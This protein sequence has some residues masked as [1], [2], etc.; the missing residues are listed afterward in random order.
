MT[1]ETQKS[2]SLKSAFG[3]LGNTLAGSYNV[4][5]GCVIDGPTGQTMM[6]VGTLNVAAT[7]A[8]IAWD[9]HMK[10]ERNQMMAQ[11]AVQNA[12]RLGQ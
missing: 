2:Q 1:Q 8:S 12:L 6:V 9:N 4:I 11:A 10:A 5:A 7:F 3:M